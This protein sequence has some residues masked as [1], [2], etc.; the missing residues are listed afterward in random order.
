MK[1]KGYWHKNKHI[2][3]WNKTESPELNL[4]INGQLIFHK[5]AKI[6]NGEK[7][8]FSTNS[9]GK[10]GDPHAKECGPPSH[11]M[12]KKIISQWI[13]DLKVS[14]ETIKLLE[15][16][17]GKNLCAIGLSKDFME[18][19]PKSQAIRTKIDKVGLHQT[20][21]LLHSKRHK[22]QIEKVT[23]GMRENICKSCI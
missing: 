6:S 21:K 2:D 11:T 9:T 5:S 13:K 8:V 7:I 10:T 17:K 1:T 12:Y 14:S 23:Y 19:T 18:M 15:E 22:Q 3:Q 20:K 16:N 4:H